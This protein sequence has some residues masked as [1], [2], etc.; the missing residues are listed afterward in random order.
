MARYAELHAHSAFSFLDGANQPE[1]LV[2]SAKELGLHALALTDHD[3][4]YGVVRFAQAAQEVGLATI[5]GAELNVD[6]GH[7]V[8]LARGVEGYRKLSRTIALKKLAQ[9]KKE[10]C[11]Y[12]LS[13]L[14][15]QADDAW[16]VLTGCGQGRVRQA[17]GT[18]PHHWDVDAGQK[19]LEKLVATFG[20][21]NVAVELTHDQIPGEESRLEAMVHL[22]NQVG[23]KTVATG[24]VHCATVK[25]WPL[26][27]VLASTQAGVPLDELQGQLRPAPQVM[28]SAQEM[29]ALHHRWAYALETS[30]DI[31]QQCSFDL[32]LV[33]PGLPPFPV[34]QGH[35]ESTWLKKLT[36]Q[37][38]KQRYGSP[39]H[40]PQAY[41][42]IEHELRTIA[43]LGFCGYFLIV[44]E[45]M[46]FCQE[47]DILCQGRGSAANSAVCFALGITAVDAVK[48]KLLFERFLSP[49][50]SGPP[51]IDIDIEADR[52]EE[53]IQFVY[54]RYGRH[55]AAQVAN[56]I[57]YRMRSA[58]RDTARALGYD[59][60]QQEAWSKSLERGQPLTPDIPP[61]VADIAQQLLT[62][63]RHLG[64]HPGGMVICD[65][66]VI[67]VVPVEWATKPGRTVVQWDKDDCAD[68]GLVKF[69]LLGLG[70]L[71]ALKKAFGMIR[72]LTGEEIGLHSIPQEDPKVYDLLCAADTVGVFQVESRAQIATLP[73]L[74]PRNFYDLVVEVALIRPGPIQGQSVHPYIERARGRQPVT[75]DHPLLKPALEKTLGVPL[76]QEQL[77]NI[78]IDV[79]GFSPSE[80]DQLRRA[81]SAKRS[82]ERMD[83][84]KQRL[85]QGMFDRGISR[86]VAEKIFTKLKG[87]ADF[88]FPES[89]AFS[90]AYLVYASAWVKVYHPEVFYAALLAS[91]PMGFYSPASLVE[92]ARRRGVV[93][94]R[95]GVDCSGVEA[96][97]HK[98]DNQLCVQLGLAPI[99]GIGKNT[100]EVIVA[101]RLKRSFT[102]MGDLI[103]RCDLNK[104]QVES[105][106]T[107]GAL[108]CFEHSRRAAMWSAGGHIHTREVKHKNFHQ[109]VLPLEIGTHAPSLPPMDDH[110]LAVADVW[111]SG[112]S[113]DS[114]PT[115]FVRSTLTS[116]GVATVAEVHKLPNKTRAY[117]AGVVTHRQRPAT[118]RGVT[119]LSIEDETGL[120]NV[121]CPQPVWNR[122]RTVARM[123]PAVI[124]RGMVEQADGVCNVV[125]ETFQ[126]LPLRVPTVSRDFH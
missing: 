114:Y 18:G 94:K 54:S 20:V 115:Q 23:V 58:L 11:R 7:L 56:V 33:S 88:G 126:H 80:A 2:R 97:V 99:R 109:G 76:F 124:I 106:A 74:Q 52:R 70:M 105:L 112:V 29:H 107:A 31:S 121:I 5:F 26:A 39:S 43:E 16:V 6:G 75:Y 55:H 47:R 10:P 102:G 42:L 9:K 85:F 90:F 4:L 81:M 117:V 41:E 110:T 89:H 82:M 1:E 61:V 62:L 46:E 22:A 68:A 101:Q 64:V 100:A 48:H 36:Y 119:F 123:A 111:A 79:A 21:D 122:Y 35:T 69:D 71:T 49:G 17:M 65:R 57:S 78:A 34:P 87:F 53:V 24:G 27:T 108:A 95:A 38:A 45:I 93:V 92:D 50:R 44:H 91:Q 67:D 19:E 37:G 25:S 72:R 77:M 84:L 60:G 116:Q 13:E 12:A 59:P 32:N 28:R 30:I 15:E 103:R 73:R 66:P 51:D 40:A 8:I 14:G 104:S 3:G 98:K 113:P 125:A 63:P 118:S 86:D 120:L 96:E 83:A